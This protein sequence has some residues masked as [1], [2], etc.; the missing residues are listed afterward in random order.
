MWRA[1]RAQASLVGIVPTLCA[2][3]G[4]EDMPDFDGIDLLKADDAKLVDRAVFTSA[5]DNPR[6][7]SWGV[8]KG[9]RKLIMDPDRRFVVL[10]GVAEFARPSFARWE[11]SHLRRTHIGNACIS[12]SSTP[13]TKIPMKSG[14][15]PTCGRTCKDALAM[16]LMAWLDRQ[17]L[18]SG[19]ARVQTLDSETREKL[20]SLGYI[21]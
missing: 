13:C 20:R 19:A 12:T 7:S 9:D 21:E 14:M 17:Y 11:S 15:S 6:Y 5:K 2:L 16:E 18:R 8:L 1:E 10:D 3:A 4:C